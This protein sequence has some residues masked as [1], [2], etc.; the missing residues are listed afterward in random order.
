MK[1]SI[2]IGMDW[3]MT[4]LQKA[5]KWGRSQRKKESRETTKRGVGDYRKES[6]RRW[7]ESRRRSENSGHELDISASEMRVLQATDPTLWEVTI[8]VKEH[9]STSGVG[10]ISG[11]NLLYRR[12]IPRGRTSG[13]IKIE[14]LVLPKS[15]RHTVMEVAHSIPLGGHLGR[16]KTTHSVSIGRPYIVI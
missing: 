5:R 14:Q 6:W 4:S 7:S 16:N 9:E 12:W 11:D 13:G 2:V 1:R 15:C 8:A 3:T 10:F